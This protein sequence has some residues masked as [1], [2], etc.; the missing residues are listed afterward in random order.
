M[1]MFLCN[2][3]V[4][5]VHSCTNWILTGRLLTPL[6]TRTRFVTEENIDH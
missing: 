6:H 1:A 2:Q 3:F 5:G 4:E